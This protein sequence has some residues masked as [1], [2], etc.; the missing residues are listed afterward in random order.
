MKTLEQFVDS[1]AAGTPA[2]GGG[3]A[4]AV[5]GALAAA[6][7][8]MVSRLTMGRPKFADTEAEMYALAAEADRVRGRLFALAAEDAAAYAAALEAVRNPEG[9]PAERAARQEQ[10]WCHA[11]EVPLEV[12]Q[13]S[14]EVCQLARRVAVAGNP[15]ALGDAAMATSLALAVAEGSYLNLRLN[16]GE[17]AS[18]EKAGQMQAEAEAL[19]ESARAE[20]EALGTLVLRRLDRR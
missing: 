8:A 2:P 17:L 6:L 13:L 12:L 10:S 20:T 16:L 9:S 18:R 15:K 14:S 3:A 1:I 19:L 11:A 4:A 7:V 5:T